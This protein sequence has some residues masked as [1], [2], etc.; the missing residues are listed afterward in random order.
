MIEDYA[1]EYPPSGDI[2]HEVYFTRIAWRQLYGGG[3]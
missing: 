1:L 2:R 3:R